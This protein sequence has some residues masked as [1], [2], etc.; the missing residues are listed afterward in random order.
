[1]EIQGAGSEIL[2]QAY[3]FTSTAIAKTLVAA[4]KCGF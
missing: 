1:V 3:S 4:K 2:V